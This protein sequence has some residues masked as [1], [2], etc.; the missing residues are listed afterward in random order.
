MLKQLNVLL[1]CILLTACS[2]IDELSR[3][4]E[5]EEPNVNKKNV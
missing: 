1:L 2:S 5:N 3:L 4:L